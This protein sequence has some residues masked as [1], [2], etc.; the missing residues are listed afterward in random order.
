MSRRNGW[1][2]R[3]GA[4]KRLRAVYHDVAWKLAVRRFGWRRWHKEAK[5]RAAR[6][7]RFESALATRGLTIEQSAGVDGEPSSIDESIEVALSD[8]G[9][10]NA[11]LN[12]TGI[13]E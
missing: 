11:Y 2:R 13:K 6:L 12:A 5:A 1:R 3:G 9:L 7:E 10:V 4:L 8:A